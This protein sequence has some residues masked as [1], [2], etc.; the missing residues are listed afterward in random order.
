M[1]RRNAVSQFA[2][3]PLKDYEDLRE[4]V[5]YQVPNNELKQSWKRCFTTSSASFLHTVLGLS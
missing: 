4:S 3:L 1:I 5:Q 2:L